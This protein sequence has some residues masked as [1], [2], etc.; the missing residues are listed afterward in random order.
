MADFFCKHVKQSQRNIRQRNIRATSYKYK[1]GICCSKEENNVYSSENPPMDLLE[2]VTSVQGGTFEF[3][4]PKNPKLSQVFPFPYKWDGTA[5][6][7]GSTAEHQ[8]FQ[9]QREMSWFWKVEKEDLH[10][11]V[12]SVQGGMFEFHLPKTPQLNQLYPFPYKW[13]GRAWVPASKADVQS[14]QNQR[15]NHPGS[16]ILTM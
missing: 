7:P 5:W 12:T 1:M 6:V 13:D 3:H 8:S 15:S 14:L 2:V 4:L 11:V 16:S 9:F 10:Q